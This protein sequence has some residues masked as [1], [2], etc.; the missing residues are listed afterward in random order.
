MDTM[1]QVTRPSAAPVRHLVE[2]MLIPD[3]PHAELLRAARDALCAA[4]LARGITLFVSESWDELEAVNRANRASWVPILH[5]APSLPTFW[6]GGVDAG[7]EG[8]GEVVVTQA[9]LLVDC[10][11]PDR[12]FADRLSAL[13][14][15]YDDPRSEAPIEERCFVGGGSLAWE[16]HGA[17]CWIVAGWVQPDYRGGRGDADLFH[18]VGRVVRLVSWLRWAPRYWTG[19][20]MPETVPSWSVERAGRRHLSTRPDILYIDSSTPRPPLHFLRICRAGALLDFGDV[21]HADTGA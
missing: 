6:V 21:A 19:V 2:T 7:A 10:T 1:V 12:S 15:L 3:G 14:V 18:L 16:T 11:G 13:D 4:A 5:R 8:T 9:G 20:V 17:V